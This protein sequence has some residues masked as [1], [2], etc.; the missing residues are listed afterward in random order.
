MIGKTEIVIG[1]EVYDATSF[2]LDFS[3]LLR[4]DYPFVLK[5]AGVPDVLQFICQSRSDGIH[6]PSGSVSRRH[7]LANGEVE[8]CLPAIGEAGRTGGVEASP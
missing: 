3:L 1:A 7:Q 6:R 4:F 5:Q 8:R 2:Y